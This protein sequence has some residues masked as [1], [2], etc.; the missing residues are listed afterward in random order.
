[1]GYTYFSYYKPC[2]IRLYYTVLQPPKVPY[3]QSCI[4]L[5]YKLCGIHL[6]STARWGALY[7]PSRVRR[8]E[9]ELSSILQRQE[10]GLRHDYTRDAGGV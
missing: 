9:L 2:G 3:I 7:Y 1:M 6:Y 4:T 10:H 8:I 5:Y